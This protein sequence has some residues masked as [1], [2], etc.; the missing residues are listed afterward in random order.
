[1]SLYT[2]SHNTIP[3]SHQPDARAPDAPTGP[4]KPKTWATRPQAN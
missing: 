1:M 3:L 2:G 4:T